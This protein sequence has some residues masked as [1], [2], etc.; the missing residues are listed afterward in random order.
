V[1]EDLATVMAHICFTRKV[2]SAVEKIQE[3]FWEASKKSISINRHLSMFLQSLE[4]YNVLIC[5][6]VHTCLD[7]TPSYTGHVHSVVSVNISYG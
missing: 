1:L 5:V 7:I 2:E 6:S 4:L 3:T